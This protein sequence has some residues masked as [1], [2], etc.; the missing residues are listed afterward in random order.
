MLGSARIYYFNHGNDVV[1]FPPNLRMISGLMNNRNASDER[2]LGLKLSCSH[3]EQT[4]Y[5]PNKQRNPAGCTQVTLGIFF[6]SCGLASGD[7]DSED[8]L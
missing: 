7:L 1:P 4:Q 2:T 8:H 3:G 6:P 5:M